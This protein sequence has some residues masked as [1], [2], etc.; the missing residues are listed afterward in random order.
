V[1]V[2]AP[3]LGAADHS[4]AVTQDLPL[5]ERL[6]QLPRGEVVHDLSLLFVHVPVGED[7][8]GLAP[9]RPGHGREAPEQRAALGPRHVVD[10]ATREDQV[11]ATRR[12]GSGH[13]ALDPAHA[14]AALAGQA[15]GLGEAVGGQVH[16]GHRR[17]QPGKEDAV[18]AL[19][20]AQIQHRVAGPDEP[21][22]LARPVGRRG[23]EDVALGIARVFP[24]PWAPG[25][26]RQR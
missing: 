25:P 10:G 5:D 17:A 12:Q 24:R 3:V 2:H 6:A 9:A 14:H 22:N 21:G 1:A 16:A 7:H 19:A 26:Y 15:P 23:A 18:A 20:A 13:V 8:V 4:L 11:E